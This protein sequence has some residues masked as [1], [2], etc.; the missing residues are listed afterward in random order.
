[1]PRRGPIRPPEGRPLI[2]TRL[3]ADRGAA[4]YLVVE[5]NGSRFASLPAEVARDL[6]LETGRT[7]DSARMA[8]LT[9]AADAEASR[10]V[11]LLVLA[12][13]PRSEFELVRKLRDRGHPERAIRAA[14]ERLR[15]AGTLDD[16][17]YA[18][19]FARTRLARGHGASRV[20][21]DLLRRGVDRRT[22]ERAVAAVE[23]QERVEPDQQVRRLLER[24]AAS[25]S[26]LPPRVQRR[27]LISF[28][29]RRGFRGREVRAL[30][31]AALEQ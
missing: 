27:R 15:A 25:V 8:R 2:V 22:A 21:S 23:Q 12:A 10:R 31:E 18:E 5:V 20:L 24:R 16:A 17:R 29:A 19:A 1:M 13:H 11:A 28:L 6:G 9:E 3:A 4:G 26:G 7:L 14:L 30:I